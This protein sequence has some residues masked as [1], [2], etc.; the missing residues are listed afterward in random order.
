MP[1]VALAVS[2]V[3]SDCGD[4]VVGGFAGLGAVPAPG[5]R[6]FGAALVVAVQ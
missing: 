6:T 3:R 5:L 1:L 4:A 2:S